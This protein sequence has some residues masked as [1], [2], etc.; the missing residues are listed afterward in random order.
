MKET[1]QEIINYKGKKFNTIKKQT[2]ITKSQPKKDR[3]QKR[4]I[5][6]INL[7]TVQTF[8]QWV[9]WLLHGYFRQQ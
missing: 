9:L 5:S 6:L 1:T 4:I 3:G 2:K 8:F 7:L